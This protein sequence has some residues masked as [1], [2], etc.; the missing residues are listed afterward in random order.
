MDAFKHLHDDPRHASSGIDS[1][2]DL[3]FW[4]VDCQGYSL[5]N[6]GGGIG[7]TSP[8]GGCHEYVSDRLIEQMERDGMWGEIGFSGYRDMGLTAKGREE[9]RRIFARKTLS[10]SAA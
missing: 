8:G 4:L 10:N 3:S 2:E 1:L 5:C 6:F 7:L 9:L